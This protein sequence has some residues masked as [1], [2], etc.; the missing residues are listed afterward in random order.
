MKLMEFAS[1]KSIAGSIPVVFAP[2]GYGAIIPLT[3]ISP[4]LAVI[5]I[6][7]TVARAA[8]FA[9]VKVVH[10]FIPTENSA[11]MDE[12]IVQ[13]LYT[14]LAISFGQTVF[15]S[16][17]GSAVT[18]IFA[19]IVTENVAFFVLG[20]GIMALSPE[21]LMPR[22]KNGMP[23]FFNSTWMLNMLNAHYDGFSRMSIIPIK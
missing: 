19:A 16:L 15:L 14:T 3:A 17:L 1:H 4:F 10:F 2:L 23:E 20:M 12:A 5:G 18:L 7:E 22:M 13:S 8:L 9:G 6:V 21:F 11:W